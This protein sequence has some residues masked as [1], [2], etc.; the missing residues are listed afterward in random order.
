MTLLE[1]QDKE[2]KALIDEI[3]ENAEE[4][5]I[6]SLLC[7]KSLAKALKQVT[8]DPKTYFE[9]IDKEEC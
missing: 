7:L 5:T 3:C 2:R 1:R 6:A 4:K 8:T 9:N